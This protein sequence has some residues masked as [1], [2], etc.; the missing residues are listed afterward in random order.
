VVLEGGGVDVFNDKR[1]RRL[2]LVAHCV[3]NQNAKLD[4]CAAYP[5][6][7]L[8]A[9]EALLREG[10]GI[11]QLPCPEL[12]C[13]GLDRGTE[14][15]T[16]TSVE[17]EDTRI[18]RRM[19]EEGSRRTCRNLVSGVVQQLDEYRK[20]GFEIVGLV[21]INGSPS[22]GVE[23][24][25]SESE[26]VAGPGVFIKVLQETCAGTPLPM[27]GIKASSPIH[28]TEQIRRLV[29]RMGSRS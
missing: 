19:S 20:H 11:L 21:G 5:G 12:V 8:E 15:G 22:C 2:V 14:R 3:L 25:W 1:S 26:E 27:V 28:A 10:V 4:A 17:A 7:I 29:S 24:T 16:V 18:G 13:L 9:S 23:T 6:A